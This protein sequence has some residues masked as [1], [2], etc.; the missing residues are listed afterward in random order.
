MYRNS[1]IVNMKIKLPTCLNSVDILKQCI[2]L[3][4]LLSSKPRMSHAFTPFSNYRLRRLDINYRDEI[5]KTMAVSNSGS[6][7]EKESKLF[8]FGHGNIG[9]AVSNIALM[10]QQDDLAMYPSINQEVY[11]NF[12]HV[13]CSVRNYDRE[14]SSSSDGNNNFSFVSFNDTQLMISCIKQCTHFLI[15]IPPKI[16]IVTLQNQQD[17][18][19]QTIR[20]FTDPVLD[21]PYADMI[22]K[23]SWIG[24][25]STTGVYGNHD[26]AWVNEC[27]ETQCDLESR[28]AVYLEIEKMWRE[29]RIN[30]DDDN[31]IIRIFRCAG[32]YGNNFSA[33]HTYNK[34]KGVTLPPINQDNSRIDSIP[35]VAINSTDTTK[36]VQYTSRIHIDDA[37][38]AIVA[39]MINRRDRVI[40]SSSTEIFNIADDEPAP[41]RKVMT[42]V[43]EI[44]HSK[45]DGRRIHQKESS[46]L[47]QKV[48]RK[49]APVLN[50]R[51]MR[52]GKDL[53]KVLNIKMKDDL[54]ANFGGLRYPT[55]RE[56]LKAILDA[57]E[58]WFS[59]NHTSI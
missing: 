29:R 56:G 50:E 53:K 7:Y 20:H 35:A 58:A 37:A 45:S 36:S 51:K 14:N 11:G 40:G 18:K 5:C 26:N 46:H 13:F 22:P 39:S 15:T 38:R 48:D 44:L 41:R 55:Y 10:Q 32:L 6:D 57:N 19:E 2:V 42:F 25:V 47:K 21:S 52:R 30:C 4:N 16:E 8:I 33:L 9:H 43:K 27:S 17:E 54:L 34:N 24:Y 59:D 12:N 28:A 3:F 1:T 49:G 23:S 31:S